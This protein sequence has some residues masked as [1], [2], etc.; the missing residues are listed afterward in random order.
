MAKRSRPL[1][2]A[3][4]VLALFRAADSLRRYFLKVLAPFEITLQQ[5]NVLRIL[6]G[7]GGQL[8]TMEIRERMME[9][10]PGITRIIDALVVKGLVKR[11]ASEHDRRQVRCLLTPPAE[12]LLAK[13]DPLMDAAD[14]RAFSRVGSSRL[15]GLV[16]ML[17]SVEGELGEA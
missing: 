17:R 10:A 6:R 4:A 2:E 13:I 8:P 3:E 15:G 14:R 5:Y 9:H 12:A 11:E 7:A 1:P 16:K